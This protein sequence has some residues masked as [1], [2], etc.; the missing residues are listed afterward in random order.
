MATRSAAKAHR[1]SLKRRRRNRAVTSTTK[2]AIKKA[3]VSIASGDPE[4]A[5][6]AVRQ[7]IS[8]LDRAAKKGVLHRGS[9]ARRKSRL[10]RRLKAVAGL[11]QTASPEPAAAKKT[12]AKKRSTAVGKRKV[13]K[14]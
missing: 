9:V 1:Q 10:Q 4:A 5:G 14:E 6:A 7:A 3:N 2:T 13:E 11:L 8:A 12:P